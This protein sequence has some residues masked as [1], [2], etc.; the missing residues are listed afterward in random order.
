MTGFPIRQAALVGAALGL[1]LW[2]TQAS[3]DVA[4]VEGTVVRV[5]MLPSWTMLI[6]LV[7]AGAAG[8]MAVVAGVARLVAPRAGLAG[9]HAAATG[10]LDVLRPGTAAALLAL[11]YLPWL[12]DWL[13]ALVLLAGPGAWLW[14]SMIAGQSLVAL[15]RQLVGRTDSDT[16]EGHSDGRLSSAVDARRDA[17]TGPQTGG[18]RAQVAETATSKSR[19]L[20]PNLTP[21]RRRWTTGVF[22]ASVLLSGT[23]AGQFIRTP[24][25]PGGDEPH[26]LIVAQSLWRD[27]DLRIENNHQRR[28]YDEYFHRDLA[29]HYL[30]RG[31]DREIYSIHPVGMP[32]LMA[33]VYAAGGYELVVLAF[34]L[35]GA[36]ALTLAWRLA[37]A[38][39]GSAAAATFGWASLAAGVPWV[40]N[41]FAIYPEIPAATATLAAFTATSG[42]RAGRDWTPPSLLHVGRF[43]ATG[44][45]IGLLPWLSTKYVVMGAAL[46]LV[47]LARI[48]LPSPAAPD[49]RRRSLARTLAVGLPSAVSLAGWFLFFHWIWGTYSPSAPYGSQRETRL[50][51]LPQG[52]P[53]LFFD[54]EYGVMLAAPALLLAIPGL[55][56]LLRRRDGAR[57][58]TL[59]L[60]A[61]CAALL[62]V[63]GAFHIWWGGSAIVGRPMVAALPLLIVPVAA[64]W[65]ASRQAPWRRAAQFALLWIGIGLT[66]LVALA[67]NGLLLVAGRDGS[68]QVLEYLSPASN[69]WTLLPSFLRQTPGE[70]AVL[71]GVW[72]AA[73]LATGVVLGLASRVGRATID[74]ERTGGAAAWSAVVCV[75]VVA[76]VSGVVAV[77][78]PPSTPPQPIDGR[79]RVRMLDELDATRRPNAVLYT[80]FTPIAAD[81]VPGL[82]PIRVNATGETTMDRDTQLFGQRL[83]LPAGTYG[84]DLV[85]PPGA[86]AVDGAIALQVGRAGPAYQSWDVAL[87][88]PGTW[89]RAFDLPVDAGF[90]GFKVTPDIAAAGPQV[91][92]TPQRVVPASARPSTRGVLA[93]ARF[94]DVQ[95]FVHGEDAWPERDGVWMRG[96]TTAELT[97]RTDTERPLTLDMRA[98]AVPVRVTVALDGVVREVSLTPGE[99]EAVTFPASPRPRALRVTTSD[100]FIPADVEPGSRDR[101]LLGSWVM[102][103]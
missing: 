47:V 86:P 88:P 61:T 67:Q 62:G 66:A 22:L 71:T 49:V 35:M 78:L 43:V 94:D 85:F 38:V 65:Q 17:G 12:A 98:G 57:R 13:P 6:A 10:A 53:G 83:S 15:Y 9:R 72:V 26:Y 33:P 34:V 100:G 42:W 52:G 24:L 69:V 8:A 91:R 79:A 29:P 84:V 102:F 89:G 64:Q 48:W 4:G 21:R 82:F 92:V 40:F 5:A 45:A 51:Y 54:Q 19:D 55:W 76:A 97:V 96:R 81:A 20:T 25:F 27:G 23:V 50:E 87:T 36:A 39:T 101:R 44:V 63:V 46:G 14:W 56:L 68:W 73:L 1:G 18:S 99:S 103:R 7:V 3:L 77:A 75:G 80:P 59:E 16:Q 30:T 41:T 31:V 95:V 28:D 93:S 32:V 74:A 58:L 90:V 70:A 37:W 11:P 2:C 60:L